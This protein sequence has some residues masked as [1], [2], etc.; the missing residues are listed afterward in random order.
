M[1]TLRLK[2]LPVLACCLL[3]IAGATLAFAQEE[4][5][6]LTALLRPTGWRAEWTGPGGSGVTEVLFVRQGDRVV[7]KI[8]LVIPYDLTCENADEVG[9][10]TVMFDGC[11]DPALRLQF[12]QEDKEFPFRGTTPRGY[13]WKFRAK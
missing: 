1:A 9:I 5:S 10:N 11:R 3:Q 7:A 8:R 6:M 4:N 13:E 2:L 12:N